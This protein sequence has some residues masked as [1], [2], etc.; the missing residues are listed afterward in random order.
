MRRLMLCAF[1][2]GLFVNFA[3]LSAVADVS[4]TWDLSINGPQGAIKASVTLKQSDE[5]V[6]GTLS[7]PQGDVAV[8]GSMTGTT[9][10][11]SFTVESPHGSGTNTMT[12]E[13]TGSTMKGTMDLGMDTASFSGQKRK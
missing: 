5:T 2:I 1:V 10:R 13:V 4:G 11:L 9:L 8:K 7:R 12:A 3:P 6:T